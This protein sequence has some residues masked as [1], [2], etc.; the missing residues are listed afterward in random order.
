VI[1][2]R[3]GQHQPEKLAQG[4]RIGCAPRSRA[5]R[6]ILRSNRS[7]AT[8][9]SGPA[10]GGGDPRP[11]RTAHTSPRRGCRSRADRES[12]SVARRTGGRHCAAGPRLPPTS[13]PDSHAAFVCPSPSA[14]CSTATGLARNTFIQ[15]CLV[16]GET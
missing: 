7:A 11:H 16:Y 9:S 2:R 4:K 5:R 8:G 3:F 15:Y 10:A 1:R 6:P 13:R 14:Q 12:D